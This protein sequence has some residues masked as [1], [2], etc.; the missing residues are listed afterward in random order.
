MYD[1]FKAHILELELDPND[2]AYYSEDD[3]NDEENDIKKNRNWKHLEGCYEK[4]EDA[5]VAVFLELMD[6]MPIETMSHLLQG[7][8]HSLSQEAAQAPDALR[9]GTR[10]GVLKHTPTKEQPPT[11]TTTTP[12]E[13]HF[14]WAEEDEDEDVT[15]V[16]CS[17]HGIESMKDLGEELWFTPDELN[18][19]RRALIRQIRFISTHHPERITTVERILA[20]TDPEPV[21]NEY[22]KSLTQQ[23]TS[24]RG[25]EGHMS[26]L[27]PQIR[28]KHIQGVLQAQSDCTIRD[29]S[30][31][32]SIETIREQS[33]VRGIEMG[34]YAQCMAKCDEMEALAA[35]VSRWEQ[36]Q[37][38][39]PSSEPTTAIGGGSIVGDNMSKQ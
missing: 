38:N 28:K 15:I 5:D 31:E 32:E 4:K 23:E 11:A 37:A 3:D 8:A 27:I 9:G 16:K 17:I 35:S 2:P 20:G 39:H 10:R 21:L 34:R 18:D 19:I 36:Q 22:L 13:K 6:D 29:Y 14:R 33:L 25:M 24:I 30:Y 12:I 7:H 26:R 1:E